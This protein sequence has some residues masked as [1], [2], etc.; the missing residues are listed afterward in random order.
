MMKKLTA[1]AAVAALL[2]G[3]VGCKT[4]E[5]NYRAAYDRAMAGRDTVGDIQ[6]TIY[7]AQRSMTSHTAVIGTDSVEIRHQRLAVTDGGGAIRE[8]LKPYNVVV[9]QFKQL[10]NAKSMRERLV[11][12]GYPS[13]FVAE[14][15]EPYYY[16]ILSSH[17]DVAEALRALKSIPAG[18]PVRMKAPLP[19]ILQT[20]R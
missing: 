13:A 1:A 5:A 12:V 20:G 16:V 3:L 8:N 17:T 15:A 4:T 9:G 18:F 2:A 14:T 11:D 10:F 6:S 19:Y 7:G